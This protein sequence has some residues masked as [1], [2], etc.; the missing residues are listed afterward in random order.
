MREWLRDPSN[1]LLVEC[2]V[3]VLVFL[4]CLC[5]NP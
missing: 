4:I 2:V 5:I 1:E 3:T